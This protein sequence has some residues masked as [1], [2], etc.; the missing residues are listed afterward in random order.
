MK[1]VVRF[2]RRLDRRLFL[3]EIMGSFAVIFVLVLMVRQ[4]SK[5]DRFPVLSEGRIAPLTIRVPKSIEIIDTIASEAEQARITSS[6]PQVFDLDPKAV[7]A[8]STRWQ[9]GLEALAQNPRWNLENAAK[10]LSERWKIRVRESDVDALRD[11]GNLRLLGRVAEGYFSLIQPYWIAED[12]VVSGGQ[13]IELINL[14]TGA[15]D[16]VDLSVNRRVVSRSQAEA[17]LAQ[18]GERRLMV[19]SWSRQTRVVVEKLLLQFV[20]PNVAFN[21]QK[22][23]ER[24]ALAL[25]S[26]QP[27]MR[28][29]SKGEVIV[30]EG[31]RV[32]RET[33]E[34]LKALNLRRD[35]NITNSGFWY[36]ILFGTLSLWLVLIFLRRQYAKVMN[37]TK[38]LVVSAGMLMISLAAFKLV[39]I[40][41]L[42]LIA[43]RFSHLPISFF[44]FLIPVAAP[45]MIL[46]LLVPMSLT[47]IFVMLYSLGLAILLDKAA[48]YGVFVMTACLTGAIFV[49]SCRTRAELYRSGLW[50]A[51]VCGISASVLVM[52]WGGDL[53]VNSQ[54]LRGLDLIPQTYDQNLVWAFL[55][56]AFGGWLSAALTLVLTPILETLLDYT[57]DLKLLE[58]ARMDHPLLRELVLKA[59]GTYHHSI[60][61]GSL[62]EA[63]A[64]AIGANALLVRVGAYYHDV[65]KIGRAEY[66]V[67]NQSHGFNP[68]DT[69]K[70]QLSA[71]I[72]ISHVKEGR[73]MA[74]KY[75]LGRAISDFIEQH[76]GKS[77]VDYFFQKAKKLAEDPRSDMDP[78][79][80]REEE[81]CYPGPNPQS[82]EAAI[83]ALADA[84][85][86]STRSLVDPTPA[87]I[88]GMINKIINR[89]LEEGL[90]SEADITLREVHAAAKAFLR[91]L[92]SIHHNRVQ[93]PGQE[94]NLPPKGG[95]S[96]SASPLS[97]IKG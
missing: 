83:L 87:R 32:N 9:V 61:V 2:L 64:E 54:F 31:Q 19:R 60:I 39:L 76:H 71:K 24:Y 25:K 49:K 35:L 59:P 69:M 5:V 97:L 42:D 27:V 52:A 40:F 17:L 6:I 62:V 8:W 82:R 77:R 58:L 92:L 38:N 75:K 29:F 14:D 4:T 20:A 73:L 44:L 53:P 26:F 51:L 43:Q 57:T 96:G 16:R 3:A 46:R 65:G 88:E 37:S 13:T 93:Y 91:I 41:E 78:V 23:D 34:L 74:E 86:A 66:F 81:F 10:Q 55:G 67:E 15:S 18:T 12:R 89:A 95:E 68:H 63:G 79:E 72:I 1:R 47:I 85:E 22:T 94:T 45:A 36:E 28:S 7:V 48:L 56:G 11:S 30:R 70:P 21:R 50:T 33:S 84:C 90:L 80:I